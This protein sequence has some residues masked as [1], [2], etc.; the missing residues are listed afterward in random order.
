LWPVKAG[1]N[2]DG[3]FYFMQPKKV[4]RCQGKT[5]GDRQGNI[6]IAISGPSVYIKCQDRD[7]RR[8]TKLTFNIPGLK[9]DLS[10]AGV[11]QEV[12][13]EGYHL[14]LEPA[15]TVVGEK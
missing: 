3:L 6:L 5:H 1:N 13:P 10:V 14:D 2:L 4:I 12:L 7:C 8:W 9:L 11:L 15:M